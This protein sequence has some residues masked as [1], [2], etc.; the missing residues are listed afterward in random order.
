MCGHKWREAC[1]IHAVN[2]WRSRR[3][4]LSHLISHNILNLQSPGLTSASLRRSSALRFR[5]ICRRAGGLEGW[6]QRPGGW[7]RA[8]NA[9]SQSHETVLKPIHYD[10]QPHLI[11]SRCQVLFLYVFVVSVCL[12]E[13]LKSPS[14]SPCGTELIKKG[15]Y[16]G[17]HVQEASFKHICKTRGQIRTQGMAHQPQR[18]NGS[19]LLLTIIQPLFFLRSF[20]PNPGAVG[21]YSSPSSWLES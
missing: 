3:A 6:R 9:A 11:P 8:L 2:R 20:F 14:S 12:R 13:A 5:S 18:D 10:L 4:L 7:H 17:I 1:I 19:F 16:F 21:F 15:Q